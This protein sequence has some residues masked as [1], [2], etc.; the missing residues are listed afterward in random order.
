[1]TE[2]SVKVDNAKYSSAMIARVKGVIRAGL[3]TK[4]ASNMTGIPLNT[5]RGWMADKSRSNIPPDP[6]ATH[7]LADT[8]K[9]AGDT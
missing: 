1:V 6:V 2:D 8:L 9:I 7:L 5:I 4:A 3:K